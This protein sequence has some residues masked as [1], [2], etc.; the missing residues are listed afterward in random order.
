MKYSV[1]RSANMKECKGCKYFK[2]DWCWRIC[3]ACEGNPNEAY[4]RVFN[5]NLKRRAWD[6]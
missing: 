2:A 6:N 5:P 3:A 1:V 4:E